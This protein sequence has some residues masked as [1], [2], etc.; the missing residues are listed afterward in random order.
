METNSVLALSSCRNL[1]L[2][3]ARLSEG[4][5][6][7]ELTEAVRPGAIFVPFVKL[8]ESFHMP[9]W[10]ATSNEDFR[11]RLR[12][13]VTLDV[14]SLIVLPIDYSVDVRISEELGEG[15]VAT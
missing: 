7:G 8:A 15:L 2:A 5:T 14:P 3:L 13:A 1:S 11:D 12:H 9:A 4:V 6:E 10:R